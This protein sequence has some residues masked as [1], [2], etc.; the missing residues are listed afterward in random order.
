M[1]LPPA[2]TADTRVFVPPP[3]TPIMIE[4]IAITCLS[5]LRLQYK[6][7]PY[8]SSRTIIVFY[9]IILRRIS[10]QDGKS[11]DCF[12]PGILHVDDFSFILLF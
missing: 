11:P 10:E 8:K 12:D 2:S 6:R 5:F 3:S 4:H 7:L 9:W 1:I